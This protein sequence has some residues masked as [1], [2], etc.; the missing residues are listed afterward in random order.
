MLWNQPLFSSK[1]FA[2]DLVFNLIS[3]VLFTIGVKPSSVSRIFD[4]S[5]PLS[6]VANGGTT[7]GE[8]GLDAAAGVDFGGDKG[9]A[10]AEYLVNMYNNPNFVVD[11]DGS[12]MAGL[13]DGSV[14]VLFSGTWDA[15]AAKEA[16]GDNF[17]AAQL[18]TITIGGEA[19]QL[20]AFA[21]SKALG[22]NPNSQNM[23]AV[24]WQIGA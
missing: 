16:L 7:F 21:G 20:C 1:S 10:V 15:Q 13:R 11:A 3:S 5:L 12:G 18:P 14:N 2:M 23:Q 24:S 17:A 6:S 9:T 4:T 22:V 8:S 19:K